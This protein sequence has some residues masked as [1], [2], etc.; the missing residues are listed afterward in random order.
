MNRIRILTHSTWNY[1]C[2]AIYFIQDLENTGGKKIKF[3]IHKTCRAE[4]VSVWTDSSAFPSCHVR[5]ANCH[6]SRQTNVPPF[7]AFMGSLLISYRVYVVTGSFQVSLFEGTLNVDKIHAWFKIANI[8]HAL[9]VP[10]HWQTDRWSFAITWYRCKISYRSLV[11]FLSRYKNRGDSRPHDILWWY[12]VTKYRTLRANRS[13]LTPGRKSPLSLLAWLISR[14][15]WEIRA[16][17]QVFP[18]L[19]CAVFTRYCII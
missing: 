10:V 12:H 8:T 7:M 6:A 9:P 15:N 14:R 5:E 17:Q 16:S 19:N 11:K 2:S 4:K 18:P 1:W 3:L 13:E